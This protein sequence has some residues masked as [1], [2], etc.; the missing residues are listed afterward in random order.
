MPKSATIK[1]RQPAAAPRYQVLE[2]P[3]LS[4][5]L[6]L[7]RS[8]T[9]LGPDRA[10]VLMNYSL[11]SPGE[12]VVRPGYTLFS[13]TLLGSSK[14]QGGQR[15]YLDSTQFT[16][17]AWGG[18]VYRPSDAGADSSVVDYST[19]SNTNAVFFPYDRILVSVMDGANR[20]RKTTGDT[21][22]TPM[23]IDAST[24]R[25]SASR[26]SSGSLSASEFEFTYSYKDRGTGHESNITTLVS[27]RLLGATGAMHLEIPNSS[28]GQVEAIVVYARNKTAGETVLRKATSFAQ[29]NTTAD[30]R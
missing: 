1:S 5:G 17:T 24:G 4:G 25:S 12:I 11:G 27:T 2:V 19:I 30:H 7:R 21:T 18:N 13:T 14:Y 6:D 26:V 10:R 9:L 20:P 28:D 3:D 16:L 22:W 8:P 15:I 23:G 29:Q